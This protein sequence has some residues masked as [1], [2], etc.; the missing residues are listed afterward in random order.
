L[1]L[2]GQPELDEKLARPEIRQLLQRI[3][4]SAHIGPMSAQRVPAYLKYRLTIAA[5]GEATD[6]RIFEANAAKLIARLSGG[7]PR[8]VNILAHKCL[9]QAFGEDEHRINV[10]HVRAAA[11]D[12][13]GL[14]SRLSWWSRWRRLWRR[15]R[16]TAFDAPVHSD[17]DDRQ[18]GSR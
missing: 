10:H 8:V 12:T 7:V 18:G 16:D 11:A 6:T 17:R 2:L 3:T 15:P 9:M 5:L 13:P 14:R 1:V 4:F